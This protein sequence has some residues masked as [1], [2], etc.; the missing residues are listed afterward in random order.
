[1]NRQEEV[2][3]II[4]KVI[5][6]G[7]P[8]IYALVPEMP[9]E[10]IRR[11]LPQLT[12]ISWKYDGSQHNGMPA[13]DTNLRM[14]ELEGLLIASFEE[15]DTSA[16]VYNR[17]GNDLKEFAYYVADPGAFMTEINRVLRPLPRFPIDI[18]FYLDEDWS[19]FQEI[20]N[21]FRGANS[22]A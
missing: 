2:S 11:A 4:G 14:R 13:P 1:M 7:R 16:H 8:V 3:G 12:V 22:A 19:N 17:T 18:R 5:E 9:P 21:L 15:K 6:G 20:I 10:A